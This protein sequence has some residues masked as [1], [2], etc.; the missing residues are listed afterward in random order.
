MI[1][2]NQLSQDAKKKVEEFM[3]AFGSKDEWEKF[4]A[5]KPFIHDI[6]KL[7]VAKKPKVQPDVGEASC[8]CAQYSPLWTLIMIKDP[9]STGGFVSL[10]FTPFPNETKGFDDIYPLD[11]SIYA[12]RLDSLRFPEKEVEVKKFFAALHD[13]PAF[14]KFPKATAKFVFSGI[15]NTIKAKFMPWKVPKW[16]QILR[17]EK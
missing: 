9:E 2:L 7:W 3:K 6:Y 4:E 14:K 8:I 17:E 1:D 13:D 10:A 11:I 15:K 5:I 12:V 16:K